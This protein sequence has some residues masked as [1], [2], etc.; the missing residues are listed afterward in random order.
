M[1]RPPRGSSEMARSFSRSALSRHR[2]PESFFSGCAANA[3]C[4]TDRAQY[5]EG[6]PVTPGHEAAGVVVA[7]G[8]GTS[9]SEK[10]RP[11]WSS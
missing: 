3:I 2:R 8:P 1:L 4:G 7:V 10:A 9:V 6:S 11:A 5:F